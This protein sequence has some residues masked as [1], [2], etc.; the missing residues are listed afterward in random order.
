LPLP[1]V[2]DFVQ[3]AALSWCG[4]DTAYRLVH[5]R[6]R[7][8][9]DLHIYRWLALAVC[10][11]LADSLRT[12]QGRGRWRSAPTSWWCATRRCQRHAPPRGSSARARPPV[13]ALAVGR[14]RAQR[15]NTPC[16]ATLTGTPARPG[17]RT[18]PDRSQ[19]LLS[20]S[21]RPCPPGG[22]RSWSGV[23][24]V[25]PAAAHQSCS[26]TITRSLESAWP[27]EADALVG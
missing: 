27:A 14:P 21:G 6:S 24:A 16:V 1:A 18:R 22:P 23:N 10:G 25:S 26:R 19:P 17:R 3:A 15:L 5:R 13:D 12:L 11:L 7:P 2:L 9:S 8:K 4:P 20:G